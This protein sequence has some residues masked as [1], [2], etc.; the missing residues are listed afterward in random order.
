MHSYCVSRQ[1]QAAQ[2]GATQ[3]A[4]RAEQRAVL[5]VL[6]HTLAVQPDKHTHTEKEERRELRVATTVRPTFLVR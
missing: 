5:A 4:G 6:G 1:H 3:A 2:P